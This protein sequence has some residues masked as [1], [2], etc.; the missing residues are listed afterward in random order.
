MENAK[1]E[2][3]DKRNISLQKKKWVQHSDRIEQKKI[4]S[5]N[6]NANMN[7]K[8]NTNL[9]T[10]ANTNTNTSTN[11]TDQLTNGWPKRFQQQPK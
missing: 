8:T 7:T 9:N 6:T 1:W 11:I 2:R 4:V 10:N 3:Q 5:T